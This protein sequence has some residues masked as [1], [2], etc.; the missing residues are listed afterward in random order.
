MK[1]SFYKYHGT[2]NDF[3]IMDNRQKK[4]FLKK[5]SIARLCHRRFGIGADGLM[6]LQKKKGYD[7]EMLYFNSDGNESSLCG[8]G[9]R[10]ITHFAKKV[11]LLK[12]NKAHFL[13]NDGEHEAVVIK[14]TVR[15]KMN[16]VKEIE[17]GT[18]YYFLQTG[19]PHC[20]KF[21]P[22]V[23][24]ADIISEAKKIRFS[25]RF[26]NEGVNV[27]FV[28]KSDNGI[29]VRT[30]ERGVE[31]ETLSC[32]TGVTASAL[33]AALRGVAS[34]ENHCEISTPG[35]ELVVRFRRQ[36]DLSFSDIWLEGPATFV[37][38]GEIDL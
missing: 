15:L 26:K 16:D 29:F 11:N 28:E 6:L 33:A 25:E 38:K 19:S 5:S 8:N 35:G 21:K 10:C 13:A 22:E 12:K 23:K 4:K 36:N 31:A 24:S 18:D 27:N 2:G 14:N 32:G 34:S 3:I 7:F 9:S 17:T 1:V 20:V 30:Y 37:Y